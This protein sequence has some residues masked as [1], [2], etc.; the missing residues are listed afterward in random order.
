MPLSEH[1]QRLLEQMERQLYADDPKLAS[2]LRGS[3]RSPALAAP[4]SSSVGSVS[5]AGLPCS[6]PASPRSSGRSVSSA[7][8]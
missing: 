4:R 6:W 5:S 3:G 7:S 8:W 1:E 2:T